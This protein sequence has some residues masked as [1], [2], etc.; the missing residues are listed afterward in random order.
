M[1]APSVQ[2]LLSPAIAFNFAKDGPAFSYAPTIYYD[3]KGYKGAASPFSLQDEQKADNQ[4]VQR[5]RIE[6]WVFSYP[7]SGAANVSI[8]ASSF[9]SV[10][11]AGKDNN[12]QV[13]TGGQFT[14]RAANPFLYFF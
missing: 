6:F 9:L 4:G 13:I 8:G 3:F 2:P 5:L 10:R 7:I 14:I 11:M 12:E 1:D